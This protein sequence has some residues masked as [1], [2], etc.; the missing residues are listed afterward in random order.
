MPDAHPDTERW[1]FA[2]TVWRVRRPKPFVLVI[3][4][5][6]GEAPGADYLHERLLAPLGGKPFC[7]WWMPPASWSA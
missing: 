4:G 2:D 5:P 7:R 6:D 1:T 3:D